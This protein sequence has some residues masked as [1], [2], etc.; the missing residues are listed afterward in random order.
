MTQ[1]QERFQGD[2]AIVT[3]LQNMINDREKVRLLS[4]MTPR[5]RAQFPQYDEAL[6]NYVLYCTVTIPCT[7][8]IAFGHIEKV[9]VD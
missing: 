1:L 3:R 4:K 9:G 6:L 8:Q 2:S 5:L 7:E